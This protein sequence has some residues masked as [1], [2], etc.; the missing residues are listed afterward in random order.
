MIFFYVD[1]TFHLFIQALAYDDLFVFLQQGPVH[2]YVGMAGGRT[3]YLSE[4]HT[5]SQ[6]MVV[7]AEGRSRSVLVGRV[8]IESRPLLLVEVEVDGQ[9]HSVLLQN[10]ETV[11]L[12]APGGENL[13]TK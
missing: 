7:D 11:C 4:L 1:M 8:K 13:D 6:V 10:A 5:G 2:A 3:A 9:R 12:V